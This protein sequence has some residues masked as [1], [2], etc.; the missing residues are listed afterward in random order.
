MT[1]AVHRRRMEFTKVDFC[2][3]NIVPFQN[4]RLTKFVDVSGFVGT[5]CSMGLRS[6]LSGSVVNEINV[7]CPKKMY[8]VS[9][10]TRGGIIILKNQNVGVVMEEKNDDERECHR[11]TVEHLNCHQ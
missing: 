8:S 7:I 10:C 2:L 5:A 11:G 6:G 3:W 9:R 4:K 1:T